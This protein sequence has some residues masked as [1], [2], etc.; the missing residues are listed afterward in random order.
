MRVYAMYRHDKSLPDDLVSIPYADF[1]QLLKEKEF[2]RDTL[3]DVVSDLSRLNDKIVALYSY[4]MRNNIP[5][6]DPPVPEFLDSCTTAD[7]GSDNF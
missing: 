3:A 1:D 5:F 7:C 4:C 2:F 6:P